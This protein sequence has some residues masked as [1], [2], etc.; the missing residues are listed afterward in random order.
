MILPYVLKYVVLPEG[1]GAVGFVLISSEENKYFS[2][3][4]ISRSSLDIDAIL[5]IADLLKM[6]RTCS[7]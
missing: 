5:A 1:L 3:S 2:V 4:H 6:T 7:S